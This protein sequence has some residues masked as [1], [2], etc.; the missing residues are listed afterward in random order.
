MLGK[1]KQNFLRCFKKCGYTLIE[2]TIVIALLGILIMAIAPKMGALIRSS[3]EGA[4]KGKISS[5]RSALAIYY[6]DYEGYY[7]DSLTPLMQPGN[8]YLTKVIPLYTGEHGSSYEI[9][10]SSYIDTL[11]D[12]GAWGYVNTTGNQWGTV[13]VRCTHTDVKGKIWSTY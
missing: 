8:K 7:P 4:T 2:I 5:I 12:D 11:A 6:V 3:N 13:W 10:Y 9:I 1:E